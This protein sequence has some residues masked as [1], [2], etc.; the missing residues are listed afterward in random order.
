MDEKRFSESLVTAEK[1]KS[2]KLALQELARQQQQLTVK[3]V[4]DG[5]WK[6]NFQTLSKGAFLARGT[7]VGEIVSG[8]QI[9]YAYADDQQIGEILENAPAKIYVGDQLNSFSA[10]VTAIENITVKLENT[11]VLQIYGGTLPVV[12]DEKNNKYVSAG[13]I[14]R[15]TLEPD[16]NTGVF[17]G[18][19]TAVKILKNV[20][21][22]R[23][24]KNWLLLK[25]KKEFVTACRERNGVLHG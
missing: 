4:A 23:V 13:T 10:R 12:F 25:F 7:V 11:P 22:Y 8:K 2:N 19:K 24:I 5:H 18:R 21:L 9:V 20:Q 17:S 6:V 3:A 14:Y 1:I 16:G 15:I